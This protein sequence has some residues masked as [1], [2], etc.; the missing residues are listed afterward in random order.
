MSSTRAEP[1]WLPCLD[2]DVQRRR[3]LLSRLPLSISA[4]TTREPRSA[5]WSTEACR[6]LCLAAALS[7]CCLRQ[8]ALAWHHHRTVSARCAG[9]ATNREGPSVGRWRLE[10]SSALRLISGSLSIR[11]APQGDRTWPMRHSP[12]LWPG[13]WLVSLAGDLLEDRVHQVRLRM[14]LQG[15]DQVVEEL[16]PAGELEPRATNRSDRRRNCCGLWVSPCKNTMA[17]CVGRPGVMS[18]DHDHG[19]TASVSARSQA[20]KR[21]QASA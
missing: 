9:R 16:Q 13:R 1:S 7:Q 20:A 5:A 21:A 17:R 6:R 3:V 15:V 8:P 18:R 14:R 12:G 4:C 10:R 11:S 19:S 2:V